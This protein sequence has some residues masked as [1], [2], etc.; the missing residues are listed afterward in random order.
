M[1]QSLDQ[2]EC[3]FYGKGSERFVGLFSVPWAFDA[4]PPH[5]LD[6]TDDANRR[7]VKIQ[8]RPV[9]GRAHRNIRQRTCRCGSGG[10]SEFGQDG[11]GGVIREG[12]AKLSDRI[13]EDQ[14]NIHMETRG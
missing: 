3:L 1:A 7:G 2:L 14:R 11:D 9:A 13:T 10:R 8:R 12:A 4:E 6:R 5:R